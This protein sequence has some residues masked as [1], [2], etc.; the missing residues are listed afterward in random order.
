MADECES[1]EDES[2]TGDEAATEEWSSVL[3]EIRQRMRFG[4][5]AESRLDQVAIRKWGRCVGH[6][7]TPI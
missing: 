1:V 6:D 7:L 5:D 3:S 2:V 4:E